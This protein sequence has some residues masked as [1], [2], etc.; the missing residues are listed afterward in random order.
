MSISIFSLG[1]FLCLYEAAHASEPS[2]PNTSLGSV[3]YGY[4]Q[5]SIV[6]GQVID[7]FTQPLGQ[8]FLVTTSIQSS[9]NC[10]VYQDSTQIVNGKA[11]AMTTSA[12]GTL[13]IGKGLLR[14]DAGSTLK[15]K[16]V[17]DNCTFHISGYHIE[18]GGPYSHY[19]GSVPS[20][21]SQTIH[22]TSLGKTFVIHSIIMGGNQPETCDVYVQGAMMM[23]GNLRAMTREDVHS[24]FT[25]GNIRIP[26]AEQET[27]SVHN[28][29]SS[30]ACHYYL[31]GIYVQ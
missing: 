11:G 18:S 27:I 20:N 16:A 17:G 6:S 31:E 9:R 5:G 7:V 26:V 10:D 14:V 2:Y 19:T 24:A 8:D 12:H 15:V 23:E 4:Y 13:F 1:S 25:N 29:G 22:T 30:S 3:P 28:T 21:S